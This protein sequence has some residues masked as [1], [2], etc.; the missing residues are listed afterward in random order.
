M[1]IEVKN[2]VETPLEKFHG[3]ADVEIEGNLRILLRYKH[4]SGKDGKGKFFAS[5]E[6]VLKDD[7]GGYTGVKAFVVDSN[8]LNEEIIQKLKEKTKKP[9]LEPLVDIDLP[10]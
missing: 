3:Y 10:F 1:K 4:T 5:P 8:I 6:I 9:S 2:Y 7:T